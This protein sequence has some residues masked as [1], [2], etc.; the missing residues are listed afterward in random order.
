VDDSRQE[1]LVNTRPNPKTRM[2]DH[3]HWGGWWVFPV[4]LILVTAVLIV[5]AAVIQGPGQD[6]GTADAGSAA[7][8]QTTSSPASAP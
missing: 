4:A 8:G 1:H 2:D 3:E 7:V 6:G 5:A